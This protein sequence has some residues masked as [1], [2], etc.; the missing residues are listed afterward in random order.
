MHQPYYKDPFNGINVLPWVR[1]H[2]TKDYLD[3]VK[4]LEAFPAIRQTINVVP[5]LLEQL[6]A[7][8]ENRA[9][10]SFWEMTIINPSDMTDEQKRFLLENFFLANWDNMIKTFPRYYELLTKRGLR[11][12]QN[13]IIR[14]A[15]YFSDD[16]FR[17]LQVLFNLCWIDP[18]FRS[19][20]PLLAELVAKGKNFTE[21]DKQ[22]IM[23]A[24]MNILRDI[25]PTYKRLSASGQIELSVTPFYHPI[26]P[27]LWD[28]DIARVA[29]PFVRLPHERFNHPE[30][31]VTQIRMGIDYFERIFGFRPHGMWPSEGA[32]SEEV[33]RAIAKEGIQWIATDEEILARSL[34]RALRSP[35]GFLTDA[36]SLYHPYQYENVAIFFR[37]HKLSDLVGF[38]YSGWKAENAVDDFMGKLAQIRSQLPPDRPFVV[39]IILDG[40][41]AWEYYRNDG[42]DFLRTLYAALSNDD[43][44]KTV[45]MSDFINEYGKGDQLSYVHPGSWINADFS[46]WIGHEEDNLAWDYLA[47]TRRDLEVYAAE[48]PE[49]DL[50]EAWKALYAAEG[51]DWNW[52]YGDDHSTETADVFDELFR[53]YLIRIYQCIGMDV[54]NMLFVPILLEDRKVSADSQARGFIYPKIDGYVTSYFEWFQSAWVDVSRSGGSMHRSQS[55]IAA[56]YY[57]FN[58]DNLYVRLDPLTPFTDLSE[59]I[60]FCIHIMQ[61]EH[62]KIVYRASEGH[63]AEL[64]KKIDNQWQTVKTLPHAAAKDIF[65]IE[66]PFS[67]IAV[68]PND[69]IQL[70]IDIFR[71]TSDSLT[72]NGN[73]NMERCPARGYLLI[74]VPNAD[75]EKLMWY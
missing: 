30:D 20:D 74:T 22:V 8:T 42:H 71:S 67:D 54:P 51:S 28:T 65:E 40:E 61:P 53:G 62:F 44:F 25:I 59:T 32:V 48:H 47:R 3:M 57:G 38:V 9:K 45:T 1:L 66:I 24:Q 15:K 34:G 37:D 46:I 55:L 36:V 26:L 13:D 11:C 64:R 21:N 6:I 39:P 75:Y 5:S 50:S 31:A 19:S 60:I 4:E 27:L 33:I 49:R 58:L 7:Y 52:W 2:G 68:K 43:R 41:N 10:D 56:M 18:M 72:S 12:T 73:E 35:E 63:H 70:A 29:M 69:D 23:E 16:D 17:D 14:V